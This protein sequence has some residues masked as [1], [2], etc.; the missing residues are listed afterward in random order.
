MKFFHDEF[1]VSANYFYHRNV[2]KLCRA[3]GNAVTI[4]EVERP[5]IIDIIYKKL[6]SVRNQCT[7]NV[8]KRAQIYIY[9][10]MYKIHSSKIEIYNCEKMI[11]CKFEL[12]KRP[13]NL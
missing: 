1:P 2:S 3:I 10:Y 9:I 4:L 12:R 5:V 13:R 8:L 11:I 7:V 6:D